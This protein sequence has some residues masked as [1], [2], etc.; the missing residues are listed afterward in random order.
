MVQRSVLSG[1]NGEF[2]FEQLPP[3]SY[4]L[5]VQKPGFA[6]RNRI[7]TGGKLTSSFEGMS[8]NLDPLGV[9]EGKIV[10]SDREPI[11]AAIVEALQITTANGL[12]QISQA[13]SVQSD[14]RGHFRMWNLAP[15]KYYIKAAGRAGGV[16]QYVGTTGPTIGARESFAPFYYGGSEAITAATPLDM[17]PGQQVT[18]DLTAEIRPSFTIR[19]VLI[20]FA[21]YSKMKFELVHDGDKQTGFRIAENATRGMFEI[22][23]VVA[24]TYTVRAIQGKGD[25]RLIGE[26]V[27]EVAGVDAEGVTIALQ[28]LPV[29]NLT[30]QCADCAKERLPR[31]VCLYPKSADG[32]STCLSRNQ[33]DSKVAPGDYEVIPQAVRGY[34]DSL[35]AG[36]QDLLVNRRLTVHP[37]VTLPDFILS[38]R[39]DGGTI[40]PVVNLDGTQSNLM[41]LAIPD[42]GRAEPRQS[43]GLNPSFPISDLKPG[44]YTV[45]LVAD[46]NLEFRNPEVLATLKHGVRVHVDPRGTHEVVL[47][48]LAQ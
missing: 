40:K 26:A 17:K 30:E 45:Y 38:V 7:R 15:G 32:E 46:A 37:G 44:D 27:V 21:D 47:T 41:V 9:I 1:A 31:T 28:P 5:S 13:R 14:D 4:S 42:D 35:M 8:L 22:H 10:N 20:R 34:V 24:G 2:R 3:C 25:E 23:D 36:D 29:V 33:K 43:L 16:Q 19:G 48:E 18:A 12:R 39:T 6:V 11:E